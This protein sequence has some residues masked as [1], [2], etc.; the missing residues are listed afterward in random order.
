MMRPKNPPINPLSRP[1]IP[2]PIAFAKTDPGKPYKIFNLLQLSEKIIGYYIIVLDPTFKLYAYT[3]NIETDEIIINK[4][5]DVSNCITLEKAYRYNNTHTFQTVMLFGKKGFSDGTVDLFRILTNYIKIYVDREYSQQST[6]GPYDPPL[7][8]LIEGAITQEKYI[9]ERAQYYKTPYRST[10]NLF[11]ISFADTTNIPVSRVMQEIS[12]LLVSS[13][14]I[15]YGGDLVCLNIYLNGNTDIHFDHNIS[16]TQPLLIEYNA[17]C[18]ISNQFESLP[19]LHTAYKQCEAAINLGKRIKNETTIT[20]SVPWNEIKN[21]IYKFE[22]F[23]IYYL[24]DRCMAEDHEMFEMS[25]GIR[26]LKIS[27]EYDRKH[28]LEYLR[29][30]HTYLTCESSASQAAELL[31]MHRNNV[32]YHIHKLKE[33]IGINLGNNEERLKLLIGYKLFE[34]YKAE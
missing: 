10:F 4:N 19:E 25:N 2:L 3:Q 27:E 34:L 6:Y 23:Y 15:M 20:W 7:S 8:D 14:V 11:K 28:Q 13:K 31:L 30:L 32:N 22:D 18:G 9:I 12:N 17:V 29:I 33:L 16:K 1:L 21:G 26:A 5:M 24:L